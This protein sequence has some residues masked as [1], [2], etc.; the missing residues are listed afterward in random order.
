MTRQVLIGKLSSLFPT[1]RVFILDVCIPFN[2][3][4]NGL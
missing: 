3:K 2:R 1:V 4:E